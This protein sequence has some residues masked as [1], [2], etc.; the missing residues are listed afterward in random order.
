MA[1]ARLLF[2]I[3]P[4]MSVERRC[5]VHQPTRSLLCIASRV[6]PFNTRTVTPNPVGVV[7][8]GHVLALFPRQGI[9]DGRGICSSVGP[10]R[11]G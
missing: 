10:R 7:A 9:V 1:A 5:I 11:L 6:Y 2:N 4:L 3:V 8:V